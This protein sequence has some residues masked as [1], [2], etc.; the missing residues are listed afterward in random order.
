MTYIHFDEAKRSEVCGRK[1]D[2]TYF[3]EPDH[4]SYYYGEGHPMKPQRIRMAHDLVVGYGLYKNMTVYR[5]HVATDA[6]LS[7]FHGEEYISF[8]KIAT[9][10]NVRDYASQSKR[11]RVGDIITDCPVFDG[12]YDFQRTLAG[13]SLDA[14][15]ELCSE[16]AD[17]AINWAG[18]LHHAKRNEASGFCYV[19]DIVLAILELLR[20]HPRVLYIDIDVHHGD[21]VEEAFYQTS[22]VMTVSFHKFGDFFPGTGDISDIGTGEGR[23]YALNVPLDEGITDDIFSDLFKTI[24][25]RVVEIYQPGAIVLQCGADSLAHDRLGRFNLT[26]QGHANC[27]R[28]VKSFGIPLL[29][30]GGGGY[31]IRNVSRC[32][33]YETAVALDRDQD[34]P[35]QLPMNDF[36]H[37][38]APDYKLQIQP[39]SALHNLNAPSALDKVKIECLKNVD[40]LKHAPGV[41]FA[42]LPNEVIETA[43]RR[44]ENRLA[45]I[46]IAAEKR[47]TI[48]DEDDARQQNGSMKPASALRDR[49]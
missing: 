9:P 2:V 31:T 29:L 27:V 45:N 24:I 15:H 35:N 38:Y 5:P 44:E 12:L 42:Y 11:F 10:D 23:F 21:G 1:K 47:E 28:L 36:W 13:G 8:L 39:V 20:F 34:L 32:W 26:L 43:K 17:I 14:A 40:L 7:N 22:R 18:G 33:A 37:Y 41:E 6:E 49:T 46:R 25:T 4:G 19:N 30:L 48:D 3:Y 16:S